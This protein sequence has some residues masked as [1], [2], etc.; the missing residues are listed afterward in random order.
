MLANT[1]LPERYGCSGDP[2]RNRTAFFFEYPSVIAL[3]VAQMRY[4]I[5]L[6]LR[7]VS[8]RPSS[9]A[10]SRF[11]WHVGLGTVHELRVSYSQ[12]FVGTVVPGVALQEAETENQLVDLMHRD[13]TVHGMSPKG[14]YTVDVI[15]VADSAFS[16]RC[17]AA[18]AAVHWK[19]KKVLASADG[20]VRFAVLTCQGCEVQ[21]ER[22][23]HGLHVDET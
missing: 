8:I 20:V 2:Q 5:R 3:M 9:K 12:A 4:G 23:R 10:P 13:W 22:R 15:P 19:R 6:G 1:W 14:L 18:K 7:T 17:E 11:L 16:K 21:L